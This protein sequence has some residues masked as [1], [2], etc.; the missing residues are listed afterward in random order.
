LP[1]YA[2]FDFSIFAFC[3]IDFDI[4]F[5]SSTEVLHQGLQSSSQVCQ[6]R[7]EKASATYDIAAAAETAEGEV[8]NDIDT[9]LAVA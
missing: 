4:F 7:E 3:V 1:S 8:R 6:R 2:A 5:D 9:E